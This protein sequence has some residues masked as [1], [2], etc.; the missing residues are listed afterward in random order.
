MFPSFE[1]CL[2]FCNGF[3]IYLLLLV[4]ATHHGPHLCLIPK[5]FEHHNN[6]V[7]PFSHEIMTGDQSEGCVW[8]HSSLSLLCHW[9]RMPSSRFHSCLL[10][11]PFLRLFSVVVDLLG[12][13]FF[14]SALKYYFQLSV[15][16]FYKSLTTAF[17]FVSFISIFTVCI[18]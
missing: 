3:F 15:K 14:P 16:L 11:P 17:K 10:S 1:P 13:L 8:A 2:D 7:H 18:I 9:S 4:C 12:V 5:P 6:K